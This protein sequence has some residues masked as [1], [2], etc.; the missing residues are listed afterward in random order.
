MHARQWL[1]NVNFMHV[2]WS[3][4]SKKKKSWNFCWFRRGEFNSL[5]TRHLTIFQVSFSSFL[6]LFLSFSYGQ[7]KIFNFFYAV[8]SSHALF[9]A[10]CDMRR[11]LKMIFLWMIKERSG[12]VWI[13]RG[14]GWLGPLIN[15]VAKRNPFLNVNEIFFWNSSLKLLEIIGI[16]KLM[17]DLITAQLISLR[18]GGTHNNSFCEFSTFLFSFLHMHIFWWNFSV[19][20]FFLYMFFF[21]QMP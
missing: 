21:S 17:C 1:Q 7:S 16:K 5:I 4:T 10:S 14:D 13:R 6:L 2:H 20:N 8:D 9:A 11:C 18:H 3:G 12:L 19:H 15:F